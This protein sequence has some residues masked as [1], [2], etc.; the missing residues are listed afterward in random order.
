MGLCRRVSFYL[1]LGSG[2]CSLDA[3][4]M[5]FTVVLTSLVVEQ[6]L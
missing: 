1:V 2:G 3:M 6:W 5:L 4:I